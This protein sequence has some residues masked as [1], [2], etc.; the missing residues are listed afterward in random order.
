MIHTPVHP[1]KQQVYT[2]NGGHDMVVFKAVPPER[3]HAAALLA[4]WFNAPH[5]QTTMVI[6]AGQVPVS[7]ATMEA[8]RLV[9]HLKTD[10]QLK[11][12]IDLAPY[13][14]RWP[15]MPFLG[16]MW[17]GLTGDVG[18]IMRQ[19]IGPQAGLAEAQRKFQALLDQDVALLDKAA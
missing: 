4:Q 3:R 12:F 13:G 11:G 1:I 15:A 18:A 17:G 8:E 14:W 7:K 16:K 10:E 19:E 5:A 6:T 2:R 9:A